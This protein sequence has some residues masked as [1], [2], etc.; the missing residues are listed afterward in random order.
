MNILIIAQGYPDKY[1]SVYTFVKQLVDQFAA[2]N[3]KCCVIA[4][5]SITKNKRF[6]KFCDCEGGVTL[7]RPNYLSIS[8]FHIG[9]IEPSQLLFENAVKRAY[10]RVPFVPDVVYAH[11]W[12]SGRQIYP[13]IKD[14][15]IP[16]FVATGESIIPPDDIKP[17]LQNFYDYV[18]GVIC[19]SSKN[20]DESIGHGMSTID[21]CLLAPNGVNPLF[22]YKKNKEECRDA[23]GLPKDKFII[24]FC[25]AFIH[26]KGVKVL[27]DAI[28]SIKGEPVYSLFLG[29]PL[30]ELPS[31]KNI[32]FQGPVKHEDLVTYLCAA[33]AFVLPTLH[34]GC[35]N[36]IIEAMA[37]GLPIVSSDLS[38][39]WDVLDDTNSI[40]VDP[41]N[42]VQVAEA[43]VAL[44]DDKQKRKELAEGALEKAKKLTIGERAKKII[45]FMQ[46]RK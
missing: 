9:K 39:N 17:E 1:R 20:R 12:C 37:C 31:C 19:V 44:R 35:C 40:L 34:E 46:S 3:H 30:E 11:F 16:L 42:S 27:S 22:F 43:I 2:L 13:L 5:Y 24:A 14:K 45:E 21:K 6:H 18:K 33:D 23:F 7:L 25:G 28:D 38:F 4:P 41:K 36:A 32:L 26:R 29:R 10:K 15:K 8:N